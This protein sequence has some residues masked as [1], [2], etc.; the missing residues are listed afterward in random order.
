MSWEIRVWHEDLEDR[1]RLC[2]EAGEN[3]PDDVI[4]S[5]AGSYWF[6]EV[7]YAGDDWNEENVFGEEPEGPGGHLHG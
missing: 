3:V 4:G 7:Q 1:T 6:E 2:I 5:V